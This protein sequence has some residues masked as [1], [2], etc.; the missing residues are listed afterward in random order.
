MRRMLLGLVLCFV[1]AIY[2]WLAYQSIAPGL[3]SGDWVSF[4]G[5]AIFVV[6]GVGALFAGVNLIRTSRP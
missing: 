2:L 6:P 4:V 5:T 3:N 1:G